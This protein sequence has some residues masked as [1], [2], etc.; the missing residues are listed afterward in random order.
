VRPLFTWA[1][2]LLITVVSVGAFFNLDAAVETFGLVPAE[3]WRYGGAT[4][5]TSFL[6]HGGIFHLLGNL[7]FLL[8]FGDNVEDYLGKL[9]YGLLILAATVAGDLLY[10]LVA[11]GSTMPCVGAS[12]GISGIIVF[13]ALKFPN[14]RLGFMFRYFLYFHWFQI[15]AWGAL[16]LW[17]LM[18]GVG[19]YLQLNGLSHVGATAHLGGALAGFLAWLVWR[20]SEY[21]IESSA[22]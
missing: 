11:S 1:V 13:Y 18:Q 10:L 20:K 12:G 15:P 6:L 2:A 17:L 16:A 8:I 9:R 4:F 19:T 22:A 14:A 7:Y 21:Q 5:I 3:A